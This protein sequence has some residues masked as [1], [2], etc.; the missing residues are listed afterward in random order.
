MHDYIPLSVTPIYT[1]TADVIGHLLTVQ[2]HVCAVCRAEAHLYV[3]RAEDGVTQGL[4][5]NRCRQVLEATEDPYVLA[6]ALSY[7]TLPPAYRPTKEGE[8]L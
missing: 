1:R 7:L 2:R 3:D 6:G 8:R 4:I 5:C